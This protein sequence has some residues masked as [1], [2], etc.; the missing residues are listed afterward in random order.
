MDYTTP[1]ATAPRTRRRPSRFVGDAA[2]VL[3]SAMGLGVLG[4][5]TWGRLRPKQS[6]TFG[7][8]G[9]LTV[10]GDA[11]DAGFAALLWFVGVSLLLGLAVGAFAHRRFPTSRG[12]A[13]ELWVGVSALA[14]AAVQLVAGNQ[15][16]VWR[17]PSLDDVDPGA[18]IDVLP[19]FDVPVT[20]LVA[21]FAAMLAYW[22]ML[23]LAPGEAEGEPVAGSGDGARE[24]APGEPGD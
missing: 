8:D 6:V 3:L 11:L 14:M 12:L 16:A 23:F 20:L 24:P 17:Q 22:C 13:M 10:A 4:G 7:G 1:A 15:I 2:A 19:A 5:I 18:T 21:P 9:T